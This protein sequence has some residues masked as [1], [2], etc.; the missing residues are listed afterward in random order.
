MFNLLLS[1]YFSTV[2]TCAELWGK[3][4]MWQDPTCEWS[5]PPWRPGTAV[6]GGHHWVPSHVVQCP[7]CQF[8]FIWEDNWTQEIGTELSQLSAC[9]CRGFT[10]HPQHLI[11]WV[12]WHAPVIPALRS[13]EAG[14]PKSPVVINNKFKASSGHWNCETLSEKNNWGERKK[15]KAGLASG[16]D[17]LRDRIAV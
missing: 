15:E 9:L 5:H 2:A 6:F 11:N 7:L 16:S 17:C 4:L 12:W 13:G 8:C 3:W 14:G 1:Y 10:C